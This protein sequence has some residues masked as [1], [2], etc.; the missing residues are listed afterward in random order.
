MLR[1]TSAMENDSRAEIEFPEAIRL[2]ARASAGA[3]HKNEIGMSIGPAS[4]KYSIN[5]DIAKRP[6]MAVST[7]LAVER[8]SARKPTTRHASASVSPSK[9][10]KISAGDPRFSS[11]SHHQY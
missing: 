10:S 5:A 7:R 4:A 11:G 6:A 2:S 3:S 9:S 8:G 1:P